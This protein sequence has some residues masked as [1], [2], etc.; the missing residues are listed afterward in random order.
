MPLVAIVGTIAAICS[1]VSFAPQAWKIVRTRETKDISTGMYLFTVTGFAAWV[2][3]GALLGQWPL[4]AANSICCVLSAFILM[5]KLLS[6]RG[7]NKVADAF[8]TAKH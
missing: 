2:T 6:R 3:Y 7:K 4:I 8:E 1:T 5:M